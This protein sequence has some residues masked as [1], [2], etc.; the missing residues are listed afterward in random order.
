MLDL[1]LTY[2]GISAADPYAVVCV[3]T[4]ACVLVILVVDFVV[5]V[6]RR[7]LGLFS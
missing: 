3:Y 1:V 6:F 5:S 2:L 7:L 4:T